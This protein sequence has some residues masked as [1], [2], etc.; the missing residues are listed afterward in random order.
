MVWLRGKRLILS[1]VVLLMLSVGAGAIVFCLGLYTPSYA[2][3]QQ[4]LYWL[5]DKDL[6]RES[7]QTR[8]ELANRIEEECRQG[9]SFSSIDEKIDETQQARLWTNIPLILRPWFVEKAK[10]Y[11]QLAEQHRHDY[12]DRMLD[13][14]L[15]MRGME[16]FFPSAPGKIS[17][18]KKIS[19][20]KTERTRGDANEIH[21]RKSQSGLLPMLSGE[22]E[23]LRND[24][25]KE[26]SEAVG[27][28]WTAL[29]IRFVLRSFESTGGKAST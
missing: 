26:N 1:V 2:N 15:V 18:Q 13:V 12:V 16:K 5:V 24:L 21:K 25:D 28:L 6:D 11:A 27:S 4:L 7:S 17:E 29:Q 23:R 3:R 22:I 8:L 14:L 10:K 19:L 20:A 9:W